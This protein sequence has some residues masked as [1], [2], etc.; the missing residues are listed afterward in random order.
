MHRIFVTWQPARASTVLSMTLLPLWML[1]IPGTPGLSSELIGWNIG[2]YSLILYPIS[3]ILNMHAYKS[4]KRK[5]RE[6]D[7]DEELR[8]RYQ[9]LLLCAGYFRRGHEHCL[10]TCNRC[11]KAL[12]A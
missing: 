10:D 7:S 9:I 6:N 1:G 2:F 12:A 5:L 8:I 3:T 4:H 11:Y